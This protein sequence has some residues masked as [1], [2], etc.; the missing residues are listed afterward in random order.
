[1]IGPP[2]P[3]VRTSSRRTSPAGPRAGCSCELLLSLCAAESVQGVLAAHGLDVARLRALVDELHAEVETEPADWRLRITQRGG[4]AADPDLD[5]LLAL[6]RSADS[7]AYQLLERA[8]AACGALRK[9][10]IDRLRALEAAALNGTGPVRHVSSAMA[11]E[12]ATPRRPVVQRMSTARGERPL[13]RSLADGRPTEPA[14]RTPNARA[15]DAPRPTRGGARPWPEDQPRVRLEP[16]RPT[17]VRTWPEDH[18]ARLRLDAAR[19]AGDDARARPADRTWPEDQ[20]ARA[21]T[22]PE[23]QPAR[24]RTWP[25]DQPDA[26]GA[27]RPTREQPRLLARPEPR[28][29]RAAALS[30]RTGTSPQ[31]AT[32][33]EPEP[34]PAPAPQPE[35]RNHRLVPI[36]PSALPP[37][38]GREGEL[39]R[40]ADAVLRRSPRPP[41][42]VGPAG[43][44]RTLVAKHLA[45]LLHQPV[46]YLSATR[47]EDEDGL[48]ADLAAV[49]KQGG[50]AILDDLDRLGGD[51]PPALLGALAKAWSSGQPPI[52]A[53]A[54]PEGQARLGAWAPGLTAALDLVTLAP[55]EGDDLRAAVAAGAPA[56][57]AQ[58]GLSLGSGSRLA[59]LVRLADRFLA[60]LAQPGRSLDLLDLAC[61]RTAREG[62]GA[63]QRDTWI[64]IV[65]E[66]S[67]VPR[68][69]LEGQGHQ[70]MLE[71]EAELARKVVGHEHALSAIS[72][73]IRRNRAGF[74]SQRPIATVLLLGPS[75]V[76]K[77]EIAKALCGALFDR[78]D[79]FVRLD[80][81]EYAEAHAVARIVGAPPGYVGH[82]QGGALTDP[83]LKQPHCVVLLDEIEKAHR[84]VHQL[85]LQVFDEGR[86]TDGRGRTID[87]RH[88]AIVMTSNLGATCLDATGDARL[89]E[90]RVLEAARAAFPVE[91]WNRIE[92]P[93]VLHPLG[94]AQLARICA[95]LVRASSDRLLRERGIRYRLT[96]AATCHVVGLC[97][98]D[99]SLGARPL[100]HVLTRSVEALLA[101]A[102]L[103]GQIRAGMQVEVD[104]D[105]AGALVLLASRG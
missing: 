31:A 72:Q 40:L 39:A 9:L 96:D 12:T 24:A 55:L 18:P 92:A 1:M 37:L 65:C 99:M 61:A 86:L 43:S 22:W 59:E 88:A 17:D 78:P 90:A 6:V 3:G 23:D 104:L 32:A 5:L 62:R 41:L 50:V 87:F 63:V 58:H 21:R 79:A 66:R 34:R 42:L 28:P 53:V 33:V 44:G 67:G 81:S 14:V 13:R 16:A 68:E 52:V 76:G 84:D 51:G 4:R 100:R 54:S 38:H 49:A 98:K 70:D 45:G 75:G 64:D 60:G 11:G 19:P 101:D 7:H 27:L 26:R 83:L 36:D 25:E 20:P 15:D 30:P 91:L 103:R 89:D 94:E 97:G 102:I 29:G 82:E 10:L 56:V 46:F 47:Y 74:G 85:L 69:R 73:L 93:L 95:R 57:L 8:G 80:M 77:T 105:H 35:A 2:E 48:R 71:L